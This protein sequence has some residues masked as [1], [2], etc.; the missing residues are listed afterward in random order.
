MFESKKN[1][2]VT[3]GIAEKVPIRHSVFSMVPD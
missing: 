3:R 2:F 1:R